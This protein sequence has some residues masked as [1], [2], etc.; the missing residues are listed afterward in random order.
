[1]KIRDWTT[2]GAM[3]IGVAGVGIAAK[4]LLP[5]NFATEQMYGQQEEIVDASTWPEIEVSFLRCGHVNLPEF[6]VVRGALSIATHT[7]R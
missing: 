3:V 5:E 7:R 2:L 6:L 1:M 4:S